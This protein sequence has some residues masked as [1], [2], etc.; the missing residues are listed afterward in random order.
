MT[1]V[2]MLISVPKETTAADAASPSHPPRR[3]DLPTECRLLS[4]DGW[5]GGL[6]TTVAAP[7]SAGPP[8]PEAGIT[9][10][11]TPDWGAPRPFAPADCLVAASDPTAG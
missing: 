2:A 5:M 9:W 7:P 8:A 1:G 6:Y 4:A 10:A 11:L 3:N